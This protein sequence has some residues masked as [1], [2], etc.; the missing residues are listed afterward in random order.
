[1]LQAALPSIQKFNMKWY[2]GCQIRANNGCYKYDGVGQDRINNGFHTSDAEHKMNM[3][4][5]ANGYGSYGQ[6]RTY[7]DKFEQF[8]YL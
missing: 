1:M 6:T 8:W 2:K 4:D 7:E 5:W 3:F